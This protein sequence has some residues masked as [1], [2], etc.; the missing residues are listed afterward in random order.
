MATGGIFQLITND[1]KQDKL[2][3]ATEYLS[4]RLA[5]IRESRKDKQ[6]P[7]PTLSEIEKSHVLFMNAHFKPFAAMAFEYNKVSLPNATLGSELQ[8][9]IPN[10]GDF[11]NDMV[12]HMVLD[13]PTTAQTPVSTNAGDVPV[14]RWCDWPGERICQRVAFDVN[15][16]PLDE[17]YS[18]TYN[19]HRQF[20]VSED[21]MTGWSRNMGQ[22]IENRAQ[23]NYVS[24]DSI[25]APANT[26][27]TFGL[28]NG[29]Q[30]YKQAHEKLELFI[31]LLFWF[32]TDASLS[33][34]SVAI[35]YG[36]RYIKV[37]LATKEQLLRVI[38]NTNSNVA[39]T[40]P[41]TITTPNISTCDLYI[42][43]I[44]VQPDIH[45][46]FIKR[47]GFS[48]VRVHRR[49]VTNVNKSS[50]QILLQQLKWPIE[51]IYCG[52]RP[53][54][55][56]AINTNLLSPVTN[57]GTVDNTSVVD[58]AMEN[59]HRFGK[60]EHITAFTKSILGAETHLYTYKKET[61]H[62]TNI[63]IEAHGISLYNNLPSQFFNSYI[64]YAYGG[65]NIVTPRDVGLYMISFCLYPGSYQPS[66]H[67][68]V[69]RAREFYFKYTSTL[70]GTGVTPITGD[71][72]VNA[73]AI[74]FLLISDGSAIWFKSRQQGAM[75]S[76]GTCSNT[77]MKQHEIVA[78]PSP[79]IVG[80]AY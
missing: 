50:D 5:E 38:Q 4:A 20:R 41:P 59:W 76:Q 16:N 32:N 63:S 60:I 23:F 61:S 69:S 26:R 48:L 80:L 19:M 55:N 68:N 52:V 18:D 2:L 30:T 40:V 44:F 11:F 66:G 12:L 33:I 51:T 73:S 22:E 34:P 58:P 79:Y 47:I 6:D 36:Q 24:I 77:F 57:V 21:K 72:I 7:T 56:L 74:N 43:N 71:L 13:P 42:N 35:P 67:I 49:Q 37:N 39:L 53:T 8:F 64:P 28:L 15:G 17:Y 14:Y 25:D 65:W 54:T 9:S 10:F 1:G 31:P 29:H 70:I 78:L 45:D 27:A 62:I 3:M 46:I 75:V